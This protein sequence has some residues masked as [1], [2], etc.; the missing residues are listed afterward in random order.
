MVASVLQGVG[1]V[2]A[3]LAVPV[4]GG[5]DLT[6][7]FISKIGSVIAELPQPLPLELRQVGLGVQIVE[8]G[9]WGGTL[10]HVGLAFCAVRACGRQGGGRH[11]LCFPK[12]MQH[13][14]PMYAGGEGAGA[15][16]ADSHNVVVAPVSLCMP[17]AAVVNDDDQD[18]TSYQEPLRR[19]VQREADMLWGIIDC[20]RAELQGLLYAVKV[21]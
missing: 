8:G 4:A 1:A 16:P 2:S 7:T 3:T 14:T 19:F 11:S 9:P 6:A 21:R 5:Q 20:A 15:R 12:C 18:A 10:G 17:Q 13:V